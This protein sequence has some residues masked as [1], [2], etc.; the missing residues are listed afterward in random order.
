MARGAGAGGEPVHTMAD[1]YDGPRSG[2]A[3]YLGAPHWYRS[4]YL[5]GPAWDPDEDRFELTPLTPEVLAAEVEGDAIFRRWDA[6][7]RAG[8]IAWDGD[9][10]TFGALPEERARAAEL[11]DR[12]DA[13]L[14]ATPPSVLARGT[15]D[16]R[17]TRVTWIFVRDLRAEET[18]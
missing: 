2:A 12:R 14:A 13:Y 18:A 8:L 4:V 7:H 1:Y 3:D 10:E 16:A 6:Q 17:A 15:F 5:D 11:R 9:D